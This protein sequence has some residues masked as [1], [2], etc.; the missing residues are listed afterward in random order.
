MTA[1]TKQAWIGLA[2][3]AMIGGMG[4]SACLCGVFPGSRPRYA[5]TGAMVI[6]LLCWL[7]VGLFIVAHDC[8]H[9]SLA[10]G[11]PGINRFVRNTVASRFMRRS[12]IAGYMPSITIIT[13]MPARP[14]IQTSTKP[15]Q[16]IS[17]PGTC[18][19]FVEYFS[20]R[21]F[22]DP[23]GHS[24]LS[25][26]GCWGQPSPMSC[27]S[28]RCRHFYRHCSCFTSARFCRTATPANRSPT[29][30]GRGATNIPGSC[31]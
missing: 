26:S 20:L 29:G 13:A 4:L 9:G 25:I 23:D 27:C 17:Y 15:T 3:A 12:A 30:T 18:R 11:F 24:D 6:G 10:P 8:M 1:D 7:N 14:A 22:A 5:L 2:L 16:D 31:R 21:E 19:S 28:G